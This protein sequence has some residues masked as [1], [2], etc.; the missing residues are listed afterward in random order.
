MRKKQPGIVHP[1]KLSFKNKNKDILDK[2]KYK[3]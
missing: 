2:Q 3:S 1:E